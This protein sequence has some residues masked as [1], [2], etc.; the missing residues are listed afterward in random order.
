[1]NDWEPE[2]RCHGVERRNTTNGRRFL[3]HDETVRKAQLD[4]LSRRRIDLR[5][6]THDLDGCR[7]ALGDERSLRS[8]EEVTKGRV[9]DHAAIPIH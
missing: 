6:A 4:H 5:A 8:R 3:R 7:H 1:M 9:T 2:Q